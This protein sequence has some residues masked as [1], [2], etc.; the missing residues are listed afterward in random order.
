MPAGGQPGRAD[1]ER[2]DRLADRAARR[3]PGQYRDFL[4]VFDGLPAGA[5]GT[6]RRSGGRPARRRPPHRLLT[7]DALT[8]CGVSPRT[9]LTPLGALPLGALAL[10]GACGE[11]PQPQP[12][13]PPYV[14]V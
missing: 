7:P 11:P 5:L 3:S 13:S 10:A 1:A 2:G 12:T 4:D 14:N 6:P 8:M 9:P